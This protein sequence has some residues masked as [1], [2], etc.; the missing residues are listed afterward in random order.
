MICVWSK[1]TSWQIS[2][3]KFSQL[4]NLI[5]NLFWG[6]EHTWRWKGCR[7]CSES[8]EEEC[9]KEKMSVNKIQYSNATNK[10]W[11]KRIVF[12]VTYKLTDFHFPF[13]SQSFR[14]WCASSHF[15]LPTVKFYA[16]LFQ[17]VN[18]LITS[19]LLNYIWPH[20]FPF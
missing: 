1:I 3:V 2:N 6:D 19:V 17:F 11:L 4:F 20:R 7:I 13:L 16:F 12:L 5:L 18:R 8:E 14:C 15:C 9:M 10:A